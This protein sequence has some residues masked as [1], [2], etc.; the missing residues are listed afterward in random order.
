MKRNNIILYMVMPLALMIASCA[1][2]KGT[3]DY[4][5][6]NEVSITALG[7]PYSLLYKTDTLK[8]QPKL[9][10]TIDSNDPGRYSYEW[11]TTF[12]VPSGNPVLI[13]REL[14]LSFPAT[15]L[16]G[17]YNLHLRV[18]DKTT[19]V[20]WSGSTSFSI[21]N[22]TST[23]FLLI[24]EDETGTVEVDMISMLS[25]DT[26]VVKNLLKDNGLPQLKGAVGIIHTGGTAQAANIKLWVMAKTGS[27]FV[28]RTTFQ[29]STA[30]SFVNRLYTTFGMP[31]DLYPVDF[32]PRVQAV[33]GNS[34]S[35]NNRIAITNNGCVFFANLA[36]GDVYGNPTNRTAAKPLEL[37]KVAP[38]LI[39]TPGFWS[40]Y[41]VFDETNNRFMRAANT[42]TMMTA[43]VDGAG[44]PFPWDQTAN[45]RKLIYAENT[46]NFDAG[47]TLGVSFALMKDV[48]NNFHIYK[49]YAGGNGSKLGYYAIKPI[50]T[51]FALSKLYAF[52]SNRPVVFYA[53]GSKLY[54]Y[55]Y[56]TGNEKNYL[57]KDFGEE[58]TMIKC[59]IQTVIGTE[60]YVATHSEAKG[61]TLQKFTMGGD[62]NN[63]VLNA[64]EKA[65]WTGL[66]KVIKMDWRNNTL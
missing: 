60:L 49:I 20:T 45:G 57:I 29:S 41:I 26:V 9:N 63:L 35:S 1:K 7:G 27:Y 39:Y 54:G 13:S 5:A 16:A 38:Y 43:L 62:L 46:K 8:I 64:N 36:S 40:S 58:I 30:N 42:A 31:Q 17:S 10:F 14:N 66:T 6:I 32:A 37:F 4:T 61:G 52:A 47:S 18:L 53:V 33:G 56:N 23:G 15:G 28:D 11:R 65:V 24:G 12:G 19:N 48:G 50:A 21:V 2:D 59:D 44:A 3:Y 25:A 34:P 51:D 22:P 55:D